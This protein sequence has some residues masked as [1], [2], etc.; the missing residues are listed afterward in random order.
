MKRF[1]DICRMPQS[2]VKTYLTKYLK[3]KYNEVTSSDGFIYANGTF[4]VLLVAHMDTVH[5]ESVK[6]IV[7]SDGGDKISSPQGIGGDD[8]CGVYMIMQI[9]KTYNC[10]VLFTEDEE[11]GCIALHC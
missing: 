10:S 11:I 8:R 5:K 4:P 3:S 1:E 2:Q 7:Y 6:Q 9:V